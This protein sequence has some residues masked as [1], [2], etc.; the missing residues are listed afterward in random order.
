[1]SAVT[2]LTV[3]QLWAHK[4]RLVSTVLAVAIGVAFLT[5]TL[6]LGDTTRATFD[7]L[8]NHA[9]AG[10]DVVVQP[11]SLGEAESDGG[12]YVVLLD[13]AVLDQ[14]RAVPGVE[15]AEP[16]IIGM[17]RLVGKD[18]KPVGGMGPPT[19]AGN[20]V[21]DP[22]IN[23]Y[24]LVEG[25]AP[26]TDTEVVVNK[27]A[28]ETG[29]LQVGDT[30]TVQTPAPV[31]VT[32][33]GIA[34]F[35]D[36]AS[37]SGSTFTGFTLEGVQR[38]VL[39]QPGKITAVVAAGA[40]GVS[41][42]ELAARVQEVVPPGTKAVTGEEI[43]AEQKQA[44]N[45][46]F[47]DF[48]NRFLLIFAGIA[49]LVAAFS[50]YNTFS[51]IVAQRSREAALLRAL[52]ATRRQVLASSLI[53][54]VAVGVVASA[55][56]IVGGVG[57]AAML[58]GMFAAFGAEIPA[59][60]LV[61]SGGTVLAALAVGI[62]VTLLA[63]VVPA[64]RASGVA[65]LAALRD[66]A[67]DRSAASVRRIVAGALTTALGAG[68]V[69]SA[70]TAGADGVLPR[71]A[72]GSV[73]L[74]VGVVV[75]GPLLASVAT[76][77]LGW[78]LTRVSPTTGRLASRNALRNPRRTSGT[79]A[80]LMIGVAVVAL[81]T[82][83]AQSLKVSVEDELAKSFGGDLVVSMG[84]MG[85]GA[86]GFDPSMARDLAGRPEIRTAAGIGYGP[87]RLDGE[88]GGVTVADPTSLTQVMDLQATQ[89][90]LDRLGP[91]QVAVSVDKAAQR[92]WS[93][94]S[95]VP[96][97]FFDGTAERFT[98]G[99]LYEDSPLFGGVIM[100]RDDWAPHA[101][102]DRDMAVLIGLHDGVALEDGRRTVEQVAGAYAG[103]EI[104]DRDQY[105]AA[106]GGSINQSLVL[107][108]VMLVL[109][110]VIALMGI[111]NTLALAIHERTRELGLLR[112]V[113]Q[114]R[115]QVR[116]MVRGESVIIALF[117]TLSGVALGTFLG[118]A[119]VKAAAAEGIGTFS[120]APAHLAVVV[121]AGALA[122]VLAAR[123]PAKRASRLDVLSAI[124]AE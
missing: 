118:W 57:I 100:R 1:L 32:V 90:S 8:F 31:T 92:G 116:R 17:G 51:I 81:F 33:V 44:I 98:V 50:I 102:Q 49:L 15:R 113:G 54:T 104:Q 121:I 5:G 37:A 56:G 7:D 75:L 21:D 4:R 12:N 123:R 43:A 103:A 13:E 80:A 18:G 10:T 52:G 38:H 107:I 40:E 11:G 22:E 88:S 14:V 25:R 111:A 3:K 109:A 27:G 19:M 65:P 58:R 55:V 106:V 34:T 16:S 76:R 61:L 78:P 82:V 36:L 9:H 96:V 67:V 124:A 68:L 28:A 85:G 23:P 53:E 93:I 24:K 117:G 120:A 77:V 29:Q 79:A 112:A 6:V 59:N 97:A 62:V 83:F 63:G 46:D 101:V 84:M 20:W 87:V 73:L 39:R 95:E 35:G 119:L 69:L 94:G 2:T 72:A 110:I 122:G 108:Y 86:A 64:V 115:R 45:E 47:L 70:V 74:L 105:V 66:V 26:V 48:F 71:A 60:G 99:A 89:G 91:R 42:R 41:Q 30:A 114:T